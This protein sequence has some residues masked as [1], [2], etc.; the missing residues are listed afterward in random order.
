MATTTETRPSCGSHGYD[1]PAPSRATYTNDPKEGTVAKID[2]NQRKLERKE[3]GFSEIPEEGGGGPPRIRVAC[4]VPAAI[5]GFDRVISREKRTRGIEIRF[6]ALEGAQ[7]GHVVD[8]TLWDSSAFNGQI[9]D[10]ALA[11]GHEEP[12]D[13]DE[14]DDLAKVFSHK[15]GIVGVDVRAKDPWTNDKG[16]ERIDYEARFFY[17]IPAD[18]RPKKNVEADKARYEKWTEVKKAGI[19]SWEGYLKWKEDRAEKA[20]QGG[21]GR[22][23]SRNDDEPPPF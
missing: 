15:G 4:K 11:I 10:L 20:A 16:Q 8:R 17:R 9:A 1:S 13:P 18:S 22:G 23:G 19:A 14:D 6:V 3:E 7:A 21:G 12:F 2:P 5:V